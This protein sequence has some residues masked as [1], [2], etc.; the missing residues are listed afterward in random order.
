MI[1]KRF[2]VGFSAAFYAAFIASDSNVLP[3][4]GADD[5]ARGCQLYN[6]KDY[7]QAEP[8]LAATVRKF[9]KFWPGH[10]WLGHTYLA[11]GKKSLAKAEYEAVG[12]C[13]PPPSAEI[14][15]AC[16][17]VLTSLGGGSTAGAGTAALPPATPGAAST[18]AAAGSEVSDKPVVMSSVDRDKAQRLEALQKE[19][20]TKVD[21]LKNEQKQAVLD[22][23][24]NTN[25]RY[26]YPDG[27][28]KSE[29]SPAE[30][31]AI[32]QDFQQRIR[33]VQEDYKHRMSNIR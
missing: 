14:S 29:M 6:S 30:K 18:P 28:I 10:Y 8:L 24:A 20:S 9:P 17:K 26:Q 32:E 13:S 16:Q 1:S 22:G 25:R 4:F 31:E 3:A 21:A 27:T 23:D 12:S 2:L 15:A 5:F 11:Q 7:A 33:Q 19:L